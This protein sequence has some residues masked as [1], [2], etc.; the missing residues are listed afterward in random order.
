MSPSQ[1][2][3]V[4]LC[5]GCHR[6]FLLTDPW[7][8]CSAE[9]RT[10][11]GRLQPPRPSLPRQPL[12]RR[13]AGEPRRRAPT[14]SGRRRPRLR[15]DQPP[16]AHSITLEPSAAKMSDEKLGAFTSWGRL[17]GE[18]FGV[19]P[20]TSSPR[21]LSK[22]NPLD[23][24]KLSDSGL[25]TAGGGR[26][27]TPPRYPRNV[28][29]P[30]QPRACPRCGEPMQLINRRTRNKAPRPRQG[31]ERVSGTAKVWVCRP[32]GIQRRAQEQ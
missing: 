11:G 6:T 25:R 32:C 30:A 24:C 4:Q 19:P 17:A 29:A 10:I 5:D 2:V 22:T 21:E 18:H 13:S 8:V 20:P 16:P 28:S 7:D 26:A 27:G 23:L 9:S 12:E 14:L 31:V 15:T 3:D 1:R